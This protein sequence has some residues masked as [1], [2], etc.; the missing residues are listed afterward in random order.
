ME[1]L[2]AKS[3]LAYTHGGNGEAR[4]SMMRGRPRARCADEPNNPAEYSRRRTITASR[5]C[6]FSFDEDQLLRR[7][8]KSNRSTTNTIADPSTEPAAA[9]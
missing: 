6:H 1:P 3:E 4:M 7:L 9:M 5:A 8:L 2:T